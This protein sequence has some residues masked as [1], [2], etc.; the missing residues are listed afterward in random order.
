[1]YEENKMKLCEFLSETGMKPGFF[2]E[3]VGISS[4]TLYNILSEETEPSL[5]TAN[6]IYNFT[7]SFDNSKDKT[8]HVK[9]EDMLATNTPENLNDQS[10]KKRQTKKNNAISK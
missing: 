5:R 7:K 1:M 8:R 9:Y 4:T 10:V 6:A 2:C 3:K